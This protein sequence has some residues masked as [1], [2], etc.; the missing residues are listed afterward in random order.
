V[1][2]ATWIQQPKTIFCSDLISPPVSQSLGRSSK[3]YLK[4]E[5][6]EPAV[7]AQRLDG[8]RFEFRVAS[9]AW[10]TRDRSAKTMNLRAWFDPR[11]TDDPRQWLIGRKVL[12]SWPLQRFEEVSEQKLYIYRGEL[13]LPDSSTHAVSA[14]CDWT[15]IEP[16]IS[17]TVGRR[18]EPVFV[19]VGTGTAGLTATIATGKGGFLALE[20]WFDRDE[21]KKE[22]NQ[23]PAPTAPSGR[24]ST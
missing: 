17:L 11:V 13:S 22:P 7:T 3:S 20:I 19:V 8:V 5:E 24:G 4:N 15:F 9:S 23:A 2:P 10:L 18:E 21:Q 1:A 6:A 12:G 16:Q 14:L